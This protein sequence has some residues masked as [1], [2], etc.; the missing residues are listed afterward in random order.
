MTE[1]GSRDL[2]LALIGLTESAA[3][4]GKINGITR[5]Q[6]LLFLVE[7]EENITPSGT[8]FQFEAYKAGPYSSKLYDDLELLENLGLIKIESTSE[9]IKAEIVDINRITF[10]D[11]MGGFN[12]R[13]G[14]SKGVD[15]FEEKR[16]A[17]TEKGRQR[18]EALIRSGKYEPFIRG[19]RR[20]KTKYS[21][22]SLRDLLRYVYKKYPDWTTESE[23]IDEILGSK[24]V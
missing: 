8:G 17:L 24:S 16:F 9:S 20:I 23:I 14:A 5:L 1:I 15:S 4:E 3:S 22:Y 11:L 21:H 2:I 18:V 10:D 13:D 6:K 7:Q 12:E 19:I